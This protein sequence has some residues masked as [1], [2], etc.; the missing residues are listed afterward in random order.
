MTNLTKTSILFVSTTELHIQHNT[1]T[2]TITPVI[3][4]ISLV[5][6][7]EG[8]HIDNLFIIYLYFLNHNFRFKYSE[9]WQSNQI[10]KCIYESTLSSHCAGCLCKQL[11]SFYRP[12]FTSKK[13]TDLMK[14]NGVTVVC[15]YYLGQSWTCSKHKC[16]FNF[17]IKLI[18]RWGSVKNAVQVCGLLSV[19]LLLVKPAKL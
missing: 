9:F 14:A 19:I 8:S 6:L 2:H 3:M 1:H 7:N 13:G 4:N 12:D 11:F 5:S 17:N 16:T 18:I 10:H 15:D